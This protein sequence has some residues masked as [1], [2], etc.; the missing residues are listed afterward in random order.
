MTSKLIMTTT[1]I[2]EEAGRVNYITSLT[3]FPICQFF[4][5]R[6]DLGH[7][8]NFIT[9]FPWKYYNVDRGSASIDLTINEKKNTKQIFTHMREEFFLSPCLEWR[10]NE[11]GK[12]THREKFSMKTVGDEDGNFLLTSLYVCCSDRS[13]SN[14]QPQI[15]N[16]NVTKKKRRGRKH[17]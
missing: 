17:L 12:S 15:D 13:F 14:A 4:E 11:R 5:A 3:N 6:Q 1:A 10:E 7:S 2:W 9:V 16:G 8:I